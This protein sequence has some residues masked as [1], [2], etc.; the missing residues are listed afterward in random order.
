M[1][2]IFV[3]GTDTGVGKTRISCGLLQQLREQGSSV[4]GYKP[5]ASGCEKTPEGLRNEDA[6]ALQAAA[7]T[8][9]AYG[10]INPYAFVPAIAP[11]LA[12]KEVGVNLNLTLLNQAH[13]ELAAQYDWI[14]VEGAGGFL[15]P[16][17]DELTFGDWAGQRQWPVVL[18]VGMRLG[19]INHALLSA[20]A[21]ARRGHLVGW[22]ANVLSADMPNLEQN[23]DDLRARIAAPL[24]GVVAYGGAVQLNIDALKV[25]L[26]P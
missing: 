16:L 24:L 8:N 25:R 20:E 3:T 2:T 26:Q 5:V 7:Q 4:C 18:V 19:C 23:I 22:V 9:E 14:V 11:H 15:V 10:C 1:P 13:D 6:L 21:I 17:N 12:A